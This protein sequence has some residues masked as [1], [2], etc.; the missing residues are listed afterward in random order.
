MRFRAPLAVAAAGLLMLQLPSLATAAVSWSLTSTNCISVT[1]AGSTCSTEFADS[2]TFASVPSGTD[3]TATGWANSMNNDMV[4]NALGAGATLERGDISQYGG[5]LGVRN[6]DW[7]RSN[8]DGTPQDAVEGTSPEHAMD[9]NQ[10]N[11]LVLFDFGPDAVSLSEIRIG[12]CSDQDITVL[13][14]TGASPPANLD[15]TG[16]LLGEGT[17]DL[18]SNGWSLIGNYDVGA[19]PDPQ[20][21]DISAQ[22]GAGTA[23]AIYASY[24]IVGALMQQFIGG[25]CPTGSCYVGSPGND[26]VKLLT[27]AGDIFTNGVPPSGDVPEPATLLLLG[28]VLPFARKLRRKR[29]G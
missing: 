20:G 7:N 12:C 9:N 24:W 1:G 26:H 14:Y 16:R 27:L 18:T 23:G 3:V 21:V 15:L 8:N 17:E 28:G 25:P 6:A 13:A 10:R 5:G 22:T 19:A 2:R 4:T 29:A 11:D